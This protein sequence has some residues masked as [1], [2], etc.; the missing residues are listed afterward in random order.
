MSNFSH[1]QPSTFFYFFFLFLCQHK[2]P[3]FNIVWFDRTQ[4]DNWY[5]L[6]CY[7]MVME[8]L[9]EM[10]KCLTCCRSSL[11]SSSPWSKSHGSCH[12]E[13]LKSNRCQIEPRVISTMTCMYSGHWL[14]VEASS[15]DS[16]CCSVVLK[17]M[18]LM[19]CD[20]GKRKERNK[21]ENMETCHF[22]FSIMPGIS[23]C[24]HP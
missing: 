21:L 8:W 24:T 17:T 16:W 4:C 19:I 18:R 23:G 15:A 5:L 7:H 20:A 12:E 6:L 11:V 9:N 10:F 3:H 14:Y 22:Y 1:N 13:P 2:K